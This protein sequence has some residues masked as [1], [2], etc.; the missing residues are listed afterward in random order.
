MHEKKHAS[1]EEWQSRH[2]L[3]SMLAGHKVTAVVV[4]LDDLLDALARRRC[5]ARGAALR[6]RGACL[7]CP[8][9]RKGSAEQRGP[10]Q[11]LA[12]GAWASLRCAWLRALLTTA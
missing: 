11:A 5:A 7:G 6:R 9:R 3:A 1:S 12:L 4:Q 8:L 10:L 2:L